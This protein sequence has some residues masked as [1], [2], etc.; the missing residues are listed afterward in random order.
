MRGGP[1]P[2]FSSPG[3]GVVWREVGVFSHCRSARGGLALPVPAL[4]CLLVLSP[5]YVC[6]SLPVSPPR[7]F[8][9]WVAPHGA[10]LPCGLCFPPPWCC[11]LG[12]GLPFA[13]TILT[14]WTLTG[15]GLHFPH[16]WQSCVLGLEE[17]HQDPGQNLVSPG[18]CRPPSSRRP[19]EAVSP[20]VAMSPSV[21]LSL[22]GAVSPLHGRVPLRGCVPSLWPCPSPE[23]CPLSGAV[24]PLRGC[25]PSPWSCPSPRPCPL[26]VAVSPSG[27]VSPFRVPLPGC[28][29]APG[30][31]PLSVAMPLSR[32]VSL[33]HVPLWG[34]VPSLWPCP[35]TVA[36]VPGWLR[37]HHGLW[38]SAHQVV[39][40]LVRGFPVGKR[41][42]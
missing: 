28:V 27:A 22:S 42:T 16:L 7:A 13:L 35:P 26:S 37:R 2:A 30:L 31:C 32:A 15:G 39:Q 41:L 20:S 5:C 33:L 38:A 4:C 21:S 34:R 8:C 18:H 36:P 29:P 12:H 3:S 19:S 24:S 1:D 14:G 25:V 11:V 10:V 23:P 6:F 40:A 9:D 17:L